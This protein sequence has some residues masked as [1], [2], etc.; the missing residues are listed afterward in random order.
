ML[1][2]SL[3]LSTAS[4]LNNRLRVEPRQILKAVYIH[5]YRSIALLQREEFD[6]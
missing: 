3:K 1:Q 2:A 6:L 5:L 4:F